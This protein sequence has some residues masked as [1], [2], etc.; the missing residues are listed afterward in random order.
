M[1]HTNWAR[2]NCSVNYGTWQKRLRGCDG[3]LGAEAPPEHGP[4]QAK[5][6]GHGGPPGPADP[7]R[8]MLGKM[9]T[10]RG[11]LDLEAPC[12]AR[13]PLPG[14]QQS[15]GPFKIEWPELGGAFRAARTTC[16]P[17]QG[18]KG[19]RLDKGQGLYKDLE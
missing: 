3:G 19:P 10:N 15:Q 11:P 6:A 7:C 2:G 8:R 9:L 4:A 1:R 17:K 12:K 14:G 13:G 18:M 5:S 16:P